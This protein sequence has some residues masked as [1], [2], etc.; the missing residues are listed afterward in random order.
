MDH[1]QIERLR[2]TLDNLTNIRNNMQRILKDL[3][4]TE[5]EMRHKLSERN[6]SDT[7]Q[8][9]LV[10]ILTVQTSQMSLSVDQMKQDNEQL[11]T[12]VSEELCQ[13]LQKSS[14]QMDRI[15][16]FRSAASGNAAADQLLAVALLSHSDRPEDGHGEAHDADEI[17]D[18]DDEH[19]DAHDLTSEQN[20]QNSFEI[21]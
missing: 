16:E 12:A 9:R 13:L 14:K 11:T 4:A 5:E 10:D 3:T 15:S 18:E 20:S 2:E 21:D 7:S 8:K 1:V 17:R 19:S 6:D